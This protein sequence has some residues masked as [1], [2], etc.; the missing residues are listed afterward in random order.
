MPILNQTDEWLWQ[1]M[2][3]DDEGA[4]NALLRRYGPM[5][6]RYGTKL[7]AD[8]E[9]V[10]D[11]VQD[12][13]ADLWLSRHRVAQTTSVRFY[14]LA[15]LRHRV[16]R[17]ATQSQR[18]TAYT[19]TDELRFQSEFTVEERWIQTE[20]ERERLHQL[21]RLFN[22]LPDRQREA[23]YLKYYQQL[24]NE[25][26]AQVMGVSYQSASNIIYRALSS[27]RQH[28]SDELLGLALLW[29]WS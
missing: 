13:F 14:L 29:I 24:T 1:Q 10:Q 25:Q 5:L 2:Q 27:L 17:A 3:L 20:A 15:S 18:Y 4:F 26:I 16:A 22:Q 11:C 6:I 19:D 12:L 28:F 9:Q 7:F 23:L 21:N 8:R